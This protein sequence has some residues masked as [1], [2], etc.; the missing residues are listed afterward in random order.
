MPNNSVSP[1]NVRFED[2]HFWVELSDGRCIGV[3]IDWFPRLLN[4]TPAQRNDFRLMPKGIHWPSVDEDI[5]VEGLLA[6][7][8]DRTVRGRHS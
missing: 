1:V 8:G 5:S 3:P 4:A 7:R 2:K 6:G